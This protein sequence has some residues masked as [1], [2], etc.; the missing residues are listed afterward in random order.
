MINDADIINDDS[1]SLNNA[2]FKVFLF[3]V[4]RINCQHPLYIYKNDTCNCCILKMQLY[5]I[6]HF[7]FLINPLHT[8]HIS[9]RN[10]F[11]KSFNLGNYNRHSIIS[12][13][14]LK[15]VDIN[16]TVNE[17]NLMFTCFNKLF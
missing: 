17:L 9:H 8:V 1:Y 14:T 15:N 7:C 10:D 13:D 3:G 4:S 5:F 6:L 12:N 11:I 2:K 16:L